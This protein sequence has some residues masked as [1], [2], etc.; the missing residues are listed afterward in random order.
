[1]RRATVIVPWADDGQPER[2]AALAYVLGRW[3]DEHPRWP[4]VVATAPA[5]PW[6]KAD[7][8]MPAVCAARAGPVVVADA[9]VW[10]TGVT[11]AVE[12]LGEA[13]WAI[14]HRYVRRLNAAASALVYEGVAF[15]A[16]DSD[17]LAERAYVGMLGGGLFVTTRDALLSVPFDPRFRGWGGED[18]AIG[19]AFR[20]LYGEPWYGME[21]LWH[22][23]HRPQL[24]PE[25]RYGNAA[26]EALR[27]RY[28]DAMGNTT[29]MV[30]LVNEAREASTWQTRKSRSTK[31]V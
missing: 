20:C 15:T 30:R 19:S 9:D 16:L 26:N 22:L 6:V 31:K 1:L 21:P 7:A 12:A 13:T 25:R 24:R 18:F 3:A 8:V 27:L 17:S 23:W 2:A 5:E 28:R 4:V 14:P 29:E 10:S 11:A